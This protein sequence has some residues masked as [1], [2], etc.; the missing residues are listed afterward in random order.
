MEGIAYNTAVPCLQVG[1]SDPQHVFV[2][3][4]CHGT[5]LH[6]TQDNSGRPHKPTFHESHVSGIDFCTFNDDR[7]RLQEV[8][9]YRCDADSKDAPAR[10]G[11]GL[12]STLRFQHCPHSRLVQTLSSARW[13][14]PV[15]L[16]V[17]VEIYPSDV[18]SYCS[19][20][21][22]ETAKQHVWGGP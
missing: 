16:A 9:I 15:T 19:G 1:V 17:S 8:V 18:L 12:S 6:P 14:Q 22:S 10:A 21:V 5:N 7:S 3:W 2:H 4:T 11:A 13:Y 20:L